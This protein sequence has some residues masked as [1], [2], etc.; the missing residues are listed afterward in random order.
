MAIPKII[1]YCWFGQGEKGD[2]AKKCINNWKEKL[3]DYKVIEWNESNFDISC[4]EYVK[5]AYEQ[6]KYAFVADYAR[7]HAL[8]NHG[9]IY[10]D[11][12]V[13]VVNSFKPFLDS[14]VVLGFE[15]IDR[16]ATAVM[17]FEKQSKLVKEWLDTYKHRKFMYNNKMD[18]TTNVVYLTK[19]LEERGL[20]LNGKLQVL[21][22]G[23]IEIYPKEYFAPYSMG[24][25]DVNTTSNTYAIHWCEGSWV[26][27]KQLFKHKIIIFIKK[28]FGST[29][30]EKI[31]NII[32]SK[33]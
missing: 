10:M 24:D 6:K 8:Y 28:V 18:M 3:P 15:S 5:E 7:L 21:D 4:N 22:K 12:D 31:R 29:L 13:E 16:I 25:S 33:N 17:L 19:L 30:Y 14:N 23:Q 2:L 27:G 11:T 26:S 20:I 1:H 9:G 32:K